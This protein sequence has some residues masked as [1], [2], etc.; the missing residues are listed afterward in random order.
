MV[1][2]N[3]DLIGIRILPAEADAPLIVHTNTVLASAI[4]FELLEAIARR[5]PKVLERFRGVDG[6]E[7]AEHAPQEVGGK[8]ADAL[9]L[10]K[11]FGVPV[12]EALD[13]F[14]S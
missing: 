7:L 3:L 6:D 1:V 13:H 4:S 14:G 10:E 2:N 9:A 8:A 5:H 11:G 12:G